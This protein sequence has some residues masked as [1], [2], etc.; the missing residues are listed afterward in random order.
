VDERRQ[1][2]VEPSSAGT[3]ELLRQC[4]EIRLI[5]DKLPLDVH[6]RPPGQIAMDHHE[7]AAIAFKE[8]MCVGEQ[9]HHLAWPLPH[10]G[11]IL[12]ETQTVQNGALAVER[13]REKIV[14]PS[15]ANR[16]VWD[17]AGAI[18]PSPRVIFNEQAAVGVRDVA[19]I[20]GWADRQRVERL[21]HLKTE[22]LVL[23]AFDDLGVSVG[24]DITQ[25][26]ARLEIP[27]GVERHSSF[28]RR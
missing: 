15:F 13:M 9:T 19:V 24:E 18:L 10:G 27:K 5:L 16:A 25:I 11:F 26:T 20:Q 17:K 21:A 2:C 6:V 23:P 7:N 3:F 14:P 4:G 12:P 8:W 28:C 22:E 1:E